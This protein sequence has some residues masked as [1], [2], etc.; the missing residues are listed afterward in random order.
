MRKKSQARGGNRPRQAKKWLLISLVAALGGIALY[1]VT[2]PLLVWLQAIHQNTSTISISSEFGETAPSRTPG[3]APQNLLTDLPD[4]TRVPMV[5][6]GPS[7]SAAAARDRPGVSPGVAPPAAS[8]RDPHPMLTPEPRLRDRASSEASMSRLLEQPSA[9][10]AMPSPPQP[11][12]L[13]EVPTESQ[14]EPDSAITGVIPA[15]DENL[16]TPDTRLPSQEELAAPAR[17]LAAM[18][19]SRPVTPPPSPPAAPPQAAVQSFLTHLETLENLD[20]QAPRGYWRSRYLPGDPLMRVLAA[21]LARQGGAA[22]EQVVAGARQN[23]QPFDP[24]RDAALALYLAADKVAVQDTARLRLQVGLQGTPRLGGQRM[25]MDLAVVLDLRG[26]DDPARAAAARAL[27]LELVRLRQINDRFSLLL[28]DRQGVTLGPEQF[29]FG[30]LQLVLDD[31]PRSPPGN[32][33][34]ALRVA[35]RT[36]AAQLAARRDPDAPLGSSMV[37]LLTTAP[38]PGNIGRLETLAH[39]NAMA[40]IGLGVVA[41]NHES[42]PT[43]DEALALAGQGQRWLLA[44]P[45]DAARLAGEIL[46]AGS[47]VVARAVRLRVQLAPGV[48]LVEVLGAEKLDETAVQRVREVERS[49]DRRMARERGIR[50]DRGEDEAGIQLVIPHYHADT[51]HVVLLDLVV[52]G[53][54]PVAEVG[55]RYKDLVH[56]RNG[57][58]R[59]QLDLP[60]GEQPPGPLQ[61]NV[62]KN[63]LAHEVAGVLRQAG[64]DLVRERPG[65]ALQRLRQGRALLE[66]MGQHRPAW[67]QDP[68]LATDLALLD[69]AILA[70]ERDA[71][72]LGSALQLAAYRRL[73]GD[74]ENVNQ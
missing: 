64:E 44:G 73:L 62:M 36:A 35:L 26:L 68:Q 21:R 1:A 63:R 3:A 27:L 50:A 12:V 14:V 57:V 34:M 66:S 71:P 6:P 19:S 10:I 39:E 54:G 67:R 11:V 70:L 69:E 56:G 46:S 30:A 49:I 17:D 24:P 41:V 29:R 52:P 13:S 60:A 48:K 38:L 31:P 55:V 7:D 47:R 74:I 9:D 5:S 72:Y 42:R 15:D 40:G 22:L 51:T 2:T 4:L 32:D 61:H 43:A 28:A 58:A 20:F 45:A 23:W 25:A 37:L 18:P 8:S 33:T 53:P 59:S 16:L 65:A